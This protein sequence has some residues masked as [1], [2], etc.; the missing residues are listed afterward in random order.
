MQEVELGHYDLATELVL[1]KTYSVLPFQKLVELL[2][3]E[4]ENPLT[5]P[6]LQS[7]CIRNLKRLGR[8]V[9]AREALLRSFTEKKPRNACKEVFEQHF[10][11]EMSFYEIWNKVV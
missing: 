11:D 2:V 4:V 1:Q 10:A 5:S 6:V 9:E 7:N 8:N 3:L